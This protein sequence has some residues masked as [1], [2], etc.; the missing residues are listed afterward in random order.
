VTGTTAV[1]SWGAV[2]AVLG[3]A[4]LIKPTVVAGLVSSGASTPSPVIVRVLGGRQLLQGV[5]VLGRPGQRGLLTGSSVVDVLHAG[6]M[7]AGARWWPRY[8]QPAL[9]SAAVA[10]TSAVIGALLRRRSRA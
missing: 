8:R 1:R 3:A 5:T 10:G 2:T 6:S 9:A 7:I 4:M